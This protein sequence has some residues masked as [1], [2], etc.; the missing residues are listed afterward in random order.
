MIA[1]QLDSCPLGHDAEQIGE[2]QYI[3]DVAVCILVGVVCI[4]EVIPQLLGCVGL[5]DIKHNGWMCEGQKIDQQRSRGNH[6]RRSVFCR[7]ESYG[8]L[9]GMYMAKV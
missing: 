6:T 4:V 1:K 9:L 5:S 3:Q 8:M 7:S 2:T